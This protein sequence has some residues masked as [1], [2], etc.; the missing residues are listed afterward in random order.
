MRI[1]RRLGWFCI[2]LLA[3]CDRAPQWYA[4]PPQRQPIQN[5]RP[6]RMT[7][8]VDFSD[9]EADAYILRDIHKNEGA[10]WR[11]TDRRPAVSLKLRT[12]ENRKFVI[13]FTLP[14]ITF[15]DTGPVTISFFVNDHLLDRIRYDQPGM[16]HYEKLVPQPWLILDDRNTAGAEIDKM[17]TNKGGGPQYGFIISRIGLV[18]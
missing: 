18:Q 14:G 7:S 13:D 16:K 15:K 12:I 2:L 11:W 5:P 1:V 17:W 6:Y 4:P 9:P 8:T 10:V 3:S